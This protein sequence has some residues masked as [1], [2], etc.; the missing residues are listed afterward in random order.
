MLLN[1][2]VCKWK[3][4]EMTAV[5]RIKITNRQLIIVSTVG[6]IMVREMGL[7]PTR[8]W[9]HA[10]QTCLSTIPT[11]SQVRPSIIPRQAHF[12][13]RIFP[14]LMFDSLSFPKADRSVH[15]KPARFHTMRQ[16]F[17][18]IS[19]ILQVLEGCYLILIH[20]AII[21]NQNNCV[22]STFFFCILRHIPR[23]SNFL[24]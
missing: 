13:N 14:L 1:G 3:S 15:L 11:L 12:V 18:R 5:F 17:Q 16:G 6:S 20:F 21:F 24:G 7:E 19:T 22:F 23:F 10:P 9:P 4:L 2:C 8:R